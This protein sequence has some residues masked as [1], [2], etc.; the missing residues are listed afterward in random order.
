MRYK[1]LV[2]MKSVINMINE[3]SEA[4]ELEVKK[5]FPKASKLDKEFTF[6]VN[7]NGTQT[8]FKAKMHNGEVLVAVEYMHPFTH[9]QIF[10]P[11]IKPKKVVE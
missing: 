2:V 6:N 3:N 11:Y 7:I 4:V 1:N 10:T 8:K 5:Y 9:K